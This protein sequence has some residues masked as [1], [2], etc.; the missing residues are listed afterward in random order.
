MIK[1]YAIVFVGG[2]VGSV[3]R[4]SISLALQK[5]QI[6]LHG[7]PLHTFA[8]NVLGSFVIG[9]L[10]GY[11]YKNPTHWLFLLFV[12]GVCGGFT[13]FST[14]ALESVNLLKTQHFATMIV[15]MLSSLALCVSAVF[16]AMRIVG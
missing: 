13:T 5:F 12:V 1:E 14:F 7:F 10:M 16:A 4:Y 15:Y 6:L 2:G 11:L 9:L 3:L 8:V